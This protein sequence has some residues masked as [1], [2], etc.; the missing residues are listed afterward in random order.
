MANR[1]RAAL[2]AAGM[3]VT[4]SA[5]KSAAQKTLP[6]LETTIPIKYVPATGAA[7]VPTVPTVSPV[8]PKLVDDCVNYVQYGAFTGNAILLGMWNEAGQNVSTLRTNC[9]KLGRSNL[10]VLRNMSA[11]WADIQTFIS[12]S[13]TTTAAT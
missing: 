7:T 5:C 11:Q 4:V 9:D 8:A 6:T 13:Q 3:L 12:A 2:L 10:A 1:A